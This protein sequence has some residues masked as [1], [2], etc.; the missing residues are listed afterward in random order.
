MNQRK[1]GTHRNQ[2]KR[3][4]EIRL[5]PDGD[6]WRQLFGSDLSREQ[7]SCGR[8]PWLWFDEHLLLARRICEAR[9]RWHASVLSG[10][11]SRRVERGTQGREY[12]ELSAITPQTGARN[13]TQ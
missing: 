2:D 13:K 12:D 4:K 6:F 11:V 7:A 10:I 8:H 9:L 5:P 1:F 3:G